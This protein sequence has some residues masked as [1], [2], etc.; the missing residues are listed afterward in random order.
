MKQFLLPCNPD[1]NGGVALEGKNAHYLHTVRRLGVNDTILCKTPDGQSCTFT[2]IAIEPAAHGLC[3]KLK[4]DQPPHES[5]APEK[6]I[7]HLVQ[8]LPKGAKMDLIV[9]Q[10]MEA[11]ASSLTPIMSDHAVPDIADKATAKVERW[12]RIAREAFQQ[13]AAQTLITI[14]PPCSLDALVQQFTP[15][16]HGIILYCHEKM[17][18]QGTLHQYLGDHPEHVTIIIGPEG[19]LSRREVD[20][21]DKNGCKPLYLGPHVLRTETAALFCLA[22]IRII[23]LEARSWQ[24]SLP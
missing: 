10:A 4:T 7:V 19:G 22:A 21:L 17:L 11:G 2:I 12:Q 9:R 13:S 14:N 18:A 1:A 16:P 24:L 15:S 8:C 5:S 6:P 3:M 23:S 20:L